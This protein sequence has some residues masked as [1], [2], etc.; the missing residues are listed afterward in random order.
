MVVKM[1]NTKIKLDSPAV[2]ASALQIPVFEELRMGQFTLV[3]YV[4]TKFE[5]AQMK[6]AA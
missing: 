3:G 4:V 6:K 2:P 5:S 1:P